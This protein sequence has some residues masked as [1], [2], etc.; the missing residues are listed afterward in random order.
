MDYF[1]LPP[2]QRP[3]ECNKLEENY[4]NC[5]VQKAM[6]DHVMTNKCVLDSVLWFHIECPKYVAKFDDPAQ[7]RAK[8]RDFFSW[9]NR[10]AKI[11]YGTYEQDKLK[12]EMTHQFT[13]ASSK[14]IRMFKDEFEDKDPS[15]VEFGTYKE[16]QDEA[17]DDPYGDGLDPEERTF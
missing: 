15:K 2:T 17:I 11:I 5:L 10:E 3:K 6:K 13:R 16:A 4:M 12:D 8:V 14:Q 7:F 9:Q 1:Y